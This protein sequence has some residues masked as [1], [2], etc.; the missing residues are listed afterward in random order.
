MRLGPC[1]SLMPLL[2]LPS[3]RSVPMLLDYCRS[4]ACCKVF[5][6]NLSICSIACMTLFD[7]S[8]SLAPYNSPKTL[9]TT[10]HHR[11][12]LSFSQPHLDFSP[13]SESL[14]QNSST[15]SCVSQFT[16]N[17]M[18]SVNLNR[19][20]AFKATNSWPSSCN[21]SVITEPFGPGPA[22]PYRVTLKTFEFLK[23]ET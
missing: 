22:S 11:P 2:P 12:Y 21:V 3:P 15:S 19:G 8:G 6:S 23:I 9:G 20:P 16:T 4:Y 7:F 18:A 13:P 1:I 5:M 17:E 10:C 14:S